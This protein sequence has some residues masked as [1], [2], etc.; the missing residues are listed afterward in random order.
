MTGS[1]LSVLALANIAGT[2]AI[3]AVLALRLPVRRWLGARAAYA[4]WLSVP[5]A[6]ATVF[7]PARMVTIEVSAPADSEPRL[8]PV[9]T[10]STPPPEA[11]VAPSIP[12]PASAP[13]PALDPPALLTGV[14]LAGLAVSLILSFIGQRRAIR[15][16]GALRPDHRDS[17]RLRASN[18]AVGPALLGVF[19]ARLVLPADFE[20]RFDAEEQRMILAHEEAHLKAGHP[21]INGAVAL[22]RAVNWFNPLIHLAARLARIDQEMACDAIVAARYPAARQAYARALLKSQLAT[23]PL[24]LGCYWPETSKS[25]LEARITLLKTPAAPFRQGLGMTLVLL[26]ASGLGVAAWAAQPA[27]VLVE[28]IDPGAPALFTA[29]DAAQAEGIPSALPGTVS[30]TNAGGP[31][32]EFAWDEKAIAAAIAANDAA[33]VI[34]AGGSAAD[35]ATV[36]RALCDRPGQPACSHVPIPGSEGWMVGPDGSVSV[37]GIPPDTDMSSGYPSRRVAVRND[38]M[39]GVPARPDIRAQNVGRSPGQNDPVPVMERCVTPTGQPGF[40]TTGVRL[41][42]GEVRPLPVPGAIAPYI[43]YREQGTNQSGPQWMA[44]NAA[45]EIVPA[46]QARFDANAPVVLRGQVTSV[47]WINPRTLIHLSVIEPGKA[48]QAWVVWGGTPNTLQR[49]RLGRDML[50][51]GT[52]VIVRGYQSLDRKCEPE[53]IANGRELSLSDG[54]TFYIGRSGEGA[55]ADRA[56]EM[57]ISRAIAAGDWLSAARSGASSADILRAAQSR[58]RF[59]GLDADAAAVVIGPDGRLVDAF[60]LRPLAPLP[61]GFAVPTG[62]GG[63]SPTRGTGFGGYPAGSIILA[64]SDT[65]IAG[66]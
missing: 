11:F 22:L 59:A 6:M 30:L 57:A 21:L 23:A 65:R 10:A 9:E 49:N 40:C 17:R 63:A 32:V 31:T 36:L 29:Q 58:G 13:L 44:L 50:A 37:A 56:D 12:G 52:E 19:R 48:P 45:G 38:D 14:W 61:E 54:T 5:L 35:V 28:T 66:T 53:C 64:P 34:R 47:E 2:A 24:P 62:L 55:P 51:I 26:A 27:R 33:R 4:L 15:R 16:F 25:R 3:L 42:N 39:V 43:G 1:T 18:D 41:P 7:V 60:A 46:F 20:T 8:G